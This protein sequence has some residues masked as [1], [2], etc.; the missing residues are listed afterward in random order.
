MPRRDNWLGV[1]G[2]SHGLA[3]ARG[4]VLL[5]RPLATGLHVLRVAVRWPNGQAYRWTVALTVG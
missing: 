5:L 1:P 4:P 3:A 2:K